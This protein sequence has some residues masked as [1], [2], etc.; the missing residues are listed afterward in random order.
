[1]NRLLETP[2]RSGN[3]RKALIGP[4]AFH[5]RVQPPLDRRANETQAGFAAEGRRGRPAI[6]TA[7]PLR[8][9]P[10]AI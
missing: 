9:L 5:Q 10:G 3:L 8:R 6:G 7:V 4:A 1:M 2:A